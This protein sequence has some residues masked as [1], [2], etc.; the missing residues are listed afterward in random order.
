M[1]KVL[2]LSYNHDI[3]FLFMA[4]VNL[5]KNYPQV[6]RNLVERSKVKSPRVRA[7]ARKFDKE[8]FDGDR[9]YGYAKILRFDC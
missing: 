2:D 9:I 3:K 4:K 1:D 7:I 5:L 6:K 8:F